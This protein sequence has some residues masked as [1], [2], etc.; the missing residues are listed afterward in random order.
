MT[1]AKKPTIMEK[2]VNEE[3]ER[4]MHRNIIEQKTWVDSSEPFSKH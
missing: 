4:S 3:R 2:A 1:L